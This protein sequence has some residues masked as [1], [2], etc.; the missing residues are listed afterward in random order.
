MTK[1][2]YFLWITNLSDLYSTTIIRLYQWQTQKLHKKL[3]KWV[4]EVRNTSNAVKKK[5]PVQDL[6]M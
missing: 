1:C 4:G 3:H 2:L 5:H 6:E